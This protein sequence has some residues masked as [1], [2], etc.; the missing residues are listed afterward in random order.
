[1]EIYIK[2]TKEGEILI[3][4]QALNNIADVYNKTFH[5]LILPKAIEIDKK[6]LQLF[7]PLYQGENFNDKWNEATG[8]SLLGLDLSAEV[9]E[10]LYEL[11]TIDSSI[12]VNN[13]ELK[14]I[15][16][17]I[18]HVEEYLPEFDTIANRMVLV[19]LLQKEEVNQA[20]SLI[21]ELF[22]SPLIINNGDFYPR[23][24]IRTQD[25]K[26]V[27]IDW[28]TW[29]VN[30]RANIIDHPENI[31]A[32]CFVHMWN[33]KEWQKNYVKELRNRFNIKKKDF[34]KAILIKSLEMANFWYKDDRE[35]L[36]LSHNQI[37]IFRDALNE[38][39]MDELWK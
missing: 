17:L 18:F 19:N 15:P 12:V 22:T 3:Y 9:P 25:Q 5:L 24:F 33:N 27:L 1:M 35:N 37:S 34:Q 11:S 23:N 7:L 10:I 38:E 6:N 31:A 36:S 13:K 39:Y 2:K 4:E 16:R 8:G 29:N 14:N 30:S 20:R 28:E 32:Y 21:Q 26:M